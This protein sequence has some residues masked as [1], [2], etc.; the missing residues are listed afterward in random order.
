MPYRIPP[1]S[2][3]SVFQNTNTVIGF[4]Q[5]L[6]SEIRKMGASLLLAKEDYYLGRLK[7]GD[8]IV[9]VGNYPKPFRL[10]F[11]LFK[12]RKNMTDEDIRSHFRR[13]SGYSE[14]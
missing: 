13:Y 14:T 10:K 6:Q 9:K 8:A 4:N 1:I 7:V 5:R 2:P 11:P 12:I 3:N